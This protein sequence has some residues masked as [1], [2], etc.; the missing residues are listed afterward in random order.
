MADARCVIVRYPSLLEAVDEFVFAYPYRKNH[1]LFMAFAMFVRHFILGDDGAFTMWLFV[2][3]CHRATLKHSFADD[4]WQTATHPTYGEEYND[5][6]RTLLLC[7]Q[8]GGLIALPI[9]LILHILSMAAPNRQRM[10]L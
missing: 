1:E 5:I 6:A 3:L 2:A 8:H 9:E 7:Q 10:Q 4:S